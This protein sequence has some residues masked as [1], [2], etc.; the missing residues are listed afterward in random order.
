VHAVW[1]PAFAIL[2]LGCGASGGATDSAKE[3]TVTSSASTPTSGPVEEAVADLAARLDVDATTIEVVSQEAVTW[4]DG[5]LGC[6]KPGFSYTQ[7]LVEGSRITLR[8][9]GT[10]YEYHSGGSRPPSLCDKPTQ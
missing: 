1:V 7:A 8:V 3:P 10:D 2:A 4:R 6:A 9:D 5:S